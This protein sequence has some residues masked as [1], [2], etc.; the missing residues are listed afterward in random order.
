MSD[1]TGREE[2]GVAVIDVAASNVVG[3]ETDRADGKAIN[4]TQPKFANR[5][6]R[7]VYGPWVT[8]PFS[9]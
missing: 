6:H 4:A 5:I 9:P 3:K 1:P 8:A 2:G 7:M